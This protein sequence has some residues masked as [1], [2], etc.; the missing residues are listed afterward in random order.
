MPETTSPIPENLS[1]TQKD[2][3]QK[4]EKKKK[5]DKK[6]KSLDEMSPEEIAKKLRKDQRK[7]EKRRKR[8]EEKKEFMNVSLENN[9]HT[10]RKLSRP[11]FE[12]FQ[13][14]YMD[15]NTSPS[16][17]SHTHQGSFIELRY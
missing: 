10:E 5:R 7:A 14:D 13:D 3:L 12:T 16:A 8:E 1:D 4:K 6:E 9:I 15:H 11:D 17:T 2:S